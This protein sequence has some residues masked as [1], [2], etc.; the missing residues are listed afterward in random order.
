VSVDRVQIAPGGA[1]AFD[2]RWAI[3]DE[4]GKVVNAKRTAKIQTL[5]S[6]FDLD[7]G[8]IS[9]RAH[10]DLPEWTFSLVE[11][12][13]DLTSW[14][15]QFFDF[16]VSIIENAVNGFPDDLDAYVPT[17]ISPATLVAICDWATSKS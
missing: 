11:D 1:L 12:S 5:W 8:L 15:S 14:L 13:I 4:Q 6:Q 7:R 9:L 16:P 10:A 2:R 17:I 3:V